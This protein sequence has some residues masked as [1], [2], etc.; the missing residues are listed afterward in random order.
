MLMIDIEVCL[1]GWVI[2]FKFKIWVYILIYVVL[3]YIFMV[4]NC[5]RLKVN[6]VWYEIRMLKCFK[7]IVSL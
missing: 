4:E 3:S 1:W 2:I 5:Y 6:M 7:K